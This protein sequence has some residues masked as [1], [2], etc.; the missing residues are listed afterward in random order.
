MIKVLKWIGVLLGVIALIA[1]IAVWALTAKFNRSFHKKHIVRS[2]TIELPTDSASIA[3][4]KQLANLCTSC[5]GE[6]LEGKALI[7]DPALATIYAPNI[8]PGGVTAQYRVEDWVRA[9]RHGVGPDKK[10]LFVMPAQEY[11]HLSKHDLASMI[12]YLNALPPI[13]HQ[14]GDHTLTTMAKVLGS[15]GAFGTLFPAEVIDHNTPFREAPEMAVTTEYGSYMVDIGGCRTCHG[16][17]LNGGNDPNPEAP[18]G[19]NLTPGGHIGTWSEA[20]FLHTMKTGETPE[21]KQLVPEFMPWNAYG[22]L[23]DVALKAMYT[24]LRSLP[25]AESAVKAKS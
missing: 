21:G 13:D 22:Q 5:H 19:P 9:I 16:S 11:N 24:Y 18:P 1:V 20:Q 6:K 3:K 10:A 25:A 14:T 12:A 4:G 23:D 2:E 8:T 7:D 17:G 15:L